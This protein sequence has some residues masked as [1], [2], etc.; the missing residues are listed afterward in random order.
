MVFDLV[1]IVPEA[2]DT[3][4]LKSTVSDVLAVASPGHFSALSGWLLLDSMPHDMTMGSHDHRHI[5]CTALLKIGSHGMISY[6]L[7]SCAN[8][9]N[10]P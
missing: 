10:M 4:F 1:S 9:S 2:C 3:P 7:A 5:P 6:Y 8:G